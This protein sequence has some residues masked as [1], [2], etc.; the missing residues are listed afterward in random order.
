MIRVYGYRYSVYTWIVRMA[1]AERGLGYDWTEV[2]PFDPASANPHP[3]GRVPLIED[4]EL[5]IYEVRAITAFLDG[6]PG[7]SWTPEAALPRAR[8][9]QV[10]GIVDSYAY[11][12]MVREVFAPAVFAEGAPDTALIARG[13]EKS[14]PVLTALEGI[15][16]EGAVL[17]GTLTRADLHLAPMIAYFTMYPPAA[18]ALA[19]HPALANWFA[20]MRER[21]SFVR[22]IPDVPTRQ[23]RNT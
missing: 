9:E 2:N 11:W 5:R 20:G 23:P 15:A 10:I 22:T 13:M 17:N 16:Q 14:L 8:A 6:F 21:D 1:L 3:F 4:G 12:P 19:D 7:D 18:K